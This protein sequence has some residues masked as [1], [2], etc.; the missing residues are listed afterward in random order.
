MY[1]LDMKTIIGRETECKRLDKCMQA[2]TAQLVVVYG[3]RRIGKTYL[4]N[5]YFKDNIVFKVTG[6]YGQSKEIQLRNFSDELNRRSKKKR[7][8]PKDWFEAFNN[9]RE[10]IEEL[11]SKKKLVFFIDEM[12]WLDNHKSKFLAAF[13]YFWNDYGTSK[14]NLIFVIC[15]SATSWMVDNIANNKGGLFNRQTCRIYLEPFTLK[16]TKEFLLDQGISW[17]DY[18]IAECYMIM[19]GIP[20]YLSLLDASLSYVLNIDNLFFRKKAELWDEFDHLYQTLFK[21]SD[22]YIQ[23][24]KCLSEKRSGYTRKEISEKCE[25]E[26]NGKLTKILDDLVNSGFVK[27]S[28]FYGKKKKETLYESADYYTNFYFRFLKD[29]HGKDEHYWSKAIDNPSRKSWAGF[30]FEQLCKD[31]I[32]Q[33]KTKLGISGVLTEEYIWYTKTNEELG[34]CGAQIDLLIERRDR[35]INLCEIKF[36]TR[37]FVIDKDYDLKLRNKMEAFRLAT[38]TNYGLQLTMITTYGVKENKYS[39]IVGSQVTLADLFK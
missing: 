30:T 23:I 38:K 22:K 27:A 37:E 35:I 13:E 39:S 26:A 8:I 14:N 3:R 9:L 15:G 25:I 34:M 18:D 5:H 24:M 12:P 21:N 33:I 10:Y 32:E 1:N 31:H 36:S 28:S 4:V 29:N 11:S 16:Q 7:A 2:K 6:A 20:Y 19:G 17:S